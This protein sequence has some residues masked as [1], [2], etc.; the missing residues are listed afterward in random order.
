MQLNNILCNCVTYIHALGNDILATTMLTL[1]ILFITVT[2][3]LLMVIMV[4]IWNGHFVTEQ[5]IKDLGS[6]YYNVALQ[7]SIITILLVT[8]NA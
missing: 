5:A 8:V 3:L 7:I 4:I 1:I 2:C 6:S